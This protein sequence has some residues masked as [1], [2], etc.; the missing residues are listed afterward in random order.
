MDGI[1]EEIEKELE[2]PYKKL[3]SEKSSIEVTCDPLA[4]EHLFYFP[5]AETPRDSRLLRCF[6][7][8]FLAETVNPLFSAIAVRG[9]GL[10][11][12]SVFEN[13]IWPVFCVSRIWYA[14]GLM[15]T[16][17]PETRRAEA[18]EKMN[19]LENWFSEGELSVDLSQSIQIALILA[20]GKL[21]GGVES[22]IT[23]KISL[24]KNSFLEFDPFAPSLEEL[25]SLNN[26]LLGTFSSYSVKTVSD[27]N[28]G[29][30]LWVLI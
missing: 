8:A 27:E 22:E 7:H 4:R 23:G 29:G 20:E 19:I 9:P 14:D 13:E 2:W 16:K 30:D 5:G 1:L 18:R 12:E 24:M 6:C 21:F 11:P 25:C 28:F 10:L 3:E 17:Y 15:M 26:A